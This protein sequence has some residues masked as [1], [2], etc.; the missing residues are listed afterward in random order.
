MLLD[1]PRPGIDV[2][3]TV[4][5]IGAL[6]RHNLILRLRD[7]GQM[8]SYVAMPMVLMLVLRPLYVRAL[9]A[10]AT[11]VATGLMVMFSVFAISLAGNAI[12]SERTWRTWDRLRVSRAPA[13]ELL[14]GKTL[15]LF[16]V[17][18]TQQSILLVYGCLA[19]G[20]PVPPNPFLVFGAILIWAFALLAIGAALATLVRSH[21]EL[22]VITDVGALTLSSLGGALVPL[23][24]MP[25]WAQAVAPASPGYWALNLMQSAVS[26]NLAGTLRPAAVLLVIGLLAGTFAARRLA[27]GWGRGGLM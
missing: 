24:L 10:G 15:P 20:L 25:A 3:G 18:V 12:L 27:R 7:P 4:N 11:Q 6:A 8:I 9:D 19:I 1:A 21:G 2:L 23:S 17:M 13:A 5:R 22:S 14:V 26:G 16:G